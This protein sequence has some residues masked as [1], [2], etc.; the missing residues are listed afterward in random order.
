MEGLE[1]QGKEGRLA[2]GSI[3]RQLKGFYTQSSGVHSA[4]FQA[5]ES[6]AWRRTALREEKLETRRP[7]TKWY[8]SV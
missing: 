5:D 7:D 2:P 1:R 6:A 8:E 3:R 4:A